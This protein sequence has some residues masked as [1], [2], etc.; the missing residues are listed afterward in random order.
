MSPHGIARPQNQSSPNSGKK[1]PLARPLNMRNLVAIGW[2]MFEIS[3]IKI[4]TPRK[5]GPKFTPKSL[6]TC[7]P[8]KHLP[9]HAKFHRDRWN[10]LGEKRYKNLHPSIFWLPRGIP[11]PKVTVW[12]MGYTNLPLATCSNDPLRYICCQTSSILLPAWPIK[13]YSKRYVS[14]LHP[15][16]IISVFVIIMHHHHHHHH[17]ACPVTDVAFPTSLSTVGCQT[18][19]EWSEI[20]FNCP[21]P[22]E[23]RSARGQVVPW[24]S[25]PIWSTDRMCTCSVA[26]ELKMSGTDDVCE[27]WLTSSSEM[28]HQE[29]CNIRRRHHRSNASR[30]L[31]SWWKG[32]H[33]SASQRTTAER[34]KIFNCNRLKCICRRQKQIF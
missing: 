4:C 3:A 6:K 12:L 1:C 27:W 8:V 25:T 34:F 24:G 5:S 31:A 14:A 9:H 15:A 33:I 16:T 29:I 23:T 18:N 7:C 10:H 21:E 11:G 28:R 26:Q 2:G 20:W 13:T 22:G 32:H 19:V 30:F 17:V